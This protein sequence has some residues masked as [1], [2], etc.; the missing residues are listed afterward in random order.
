MMER[1]R[2]P[3][4]GERPLWRRERPPGRGERPLWRG[5]GPPGRLEGGEIGCHGVRAH[6][7]WAGLE[8]SIIILE[9]GAGAPKEIIR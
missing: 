9:M 8:E 6:N 3:R 1:R 5:E 7:P 2:K 4:R